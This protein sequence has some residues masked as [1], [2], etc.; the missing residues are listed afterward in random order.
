MTASLIRGLAPL[1]LWLSLNAHAAAPRLA[2]AH[3][4]AGG[5]GL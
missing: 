1:A 2:G 5:P 3:P 4:G